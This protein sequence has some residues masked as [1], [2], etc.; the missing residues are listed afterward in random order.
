MNLKARGTS[1][2]TLIELLVALAVIAILAALVLSVFHSVREKSRQTA[3]L[4][5]LRQLGMAISAYAQENDRL[6][7]P[8]NSVGIELGTGQ[9]I[10]EHGAQ[11]VSC[12]APYTRNRDIWF[13]ST[14][15]YARTFT[16][17]RVKPPDWTDGQVNHFYTSYGNTLDWYSPGFGFGKQ[18]ID[19]AGSSSEQS[20]AVQGP[21]LLTD[22]LWGFGGHNPNPPVPPPYSHNGRFNFLMFDGHVKSLSWE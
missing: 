7:P 2:F 1:G 18:T 16:A 19:W 3:C 20:S 9:V 12:L 10:P 14:D 13:C 15:I 22:D 4:S 17:G 21:A 8:Y 5:N 6:L 11:L